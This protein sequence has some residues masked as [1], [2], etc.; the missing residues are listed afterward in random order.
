MVRDATP[1]ESATY[2]AEAQFM[3]GWIALRYLDDPQTAYAHFV[4]VAEDN[5]NPISLARGAY[6]SGRAA[7]AMHKDQE[8]R[9]HYQEAARYPTAYYGQIARAR[10]GLGE[11]V[12]QSLPCPL[13]RRPQPRRCRRIS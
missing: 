3:A 9:Q 2:R 6:W 4:K 5:S 8:A 11:L 7:E 12:L 1:P 10:A 13:Q